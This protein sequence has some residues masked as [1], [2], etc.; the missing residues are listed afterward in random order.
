MKQSINFT[1]FMDAFHAYKRYDQ[2]GYT[3]LQI[4][5]EY[6]E[7]YEESSGEEMEMDVIALCCEYS[8]DSVADIASNYDVDLSDC[9]DDDARFETVMEY[10]RDHTPVCGDYEDADSGTRY[11]V[12]YSAF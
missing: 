1:A 3:A 11:I 10:L 7:E 5:F 12:Y 4:L 8:V 2:F 9:E 6:L